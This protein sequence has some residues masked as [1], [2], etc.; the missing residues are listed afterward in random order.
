MR[1]HHSQK[2]RDDNTGV[3]GEGEAHLAFDYCEEL[4]ASC[5]KAWAEWHE[6]D[7]AVEAKL[8]A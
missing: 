3:R 1:V 5:E 6:L 2:R 4:R 8:A 7:K